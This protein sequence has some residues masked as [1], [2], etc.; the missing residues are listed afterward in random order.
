MLPLR[1]HGPSWDFGRDIVNTIGIGYLN[2][3]RIIHKIAEFHQ[4]QLKRVTLG[5]FAYDQINANRVLYIYINWSILVNKF[6]VTYHRLII[7]S[8]ASSQ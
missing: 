8:L 7:T 6:H 5:L 1:H 3:A 2:C 4:K